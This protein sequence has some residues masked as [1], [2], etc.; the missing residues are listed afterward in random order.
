MTGVENIPS[1]LVNI[2]GT[3]STGMGAASNT[4]ITGN[5]NRRIFRN[6]IRC[7]SIIPE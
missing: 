5:E 4:G 1:G 2:T 6:F 7:K 3:A